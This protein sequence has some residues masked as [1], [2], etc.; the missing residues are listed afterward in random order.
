MS[1]RILAI[2]LIAA[3]AGGLTALLLLL[4]LHRRILQGLAAQGRRGWSLAESSRL[5]RGP[6][7]AA[8]GVGAGLTALAVAVVPV[9][10]RQAPGL[11]LPAASLGLV[12]LGGLGMVWALARTKIVDKRDE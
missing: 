3:A 1:M 11:W 4:A 2:A 10:V 8:A 6:L 12:V 5:A 7:L 9:I